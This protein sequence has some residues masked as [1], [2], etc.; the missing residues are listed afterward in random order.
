MTYCSL[1]VTNVC[2]FQFVFPDEVDDLRDKLCL[3]MMEAV[4]LT[5]ELIQSS[6]PA[7]P[8]IDILLRV[9]SS[10]F[11][12]TTHLTEQLLEYHNKSKAAFTARK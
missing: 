3:I 4:N 10:I 6:V 5:N 12:G 7:G 2:N 11:M 9:I 1:R 8:C